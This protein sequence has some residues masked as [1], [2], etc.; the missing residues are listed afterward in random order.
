M[1]DSIL[2]LQVFGAMFQIW[3]HGAVA[4]VA[5]EV[6]QLVLLEQVAHLQHLVMVKVL[7]AVAVKDRLLG[8]MERGT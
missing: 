3:K 1:A 6:Y 2:K 7:G 8:Q 5:V 4:V